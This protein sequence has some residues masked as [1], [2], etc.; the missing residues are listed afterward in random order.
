LSEPVFT[1]AKPYE[2]GC[3]PMGIKLALFSRWLNARKRYFSHNLFISKSLHKIAYFNIGFVLH[4]LH[5]LKGGIFI[6]KGCRWLMLN[7]SAVAA[8]ATANPRTSPGANK[9]I[10]PHFYFVIQYSV[11]DIHNYIR[12]TF[13]PKTAISQ[14]KSPF[15]S[16]K[17]PYS[18]TNKLMGKL[19]GLNMPPDEIVT[20][21]LFNPSEISRNFSGLTVTSII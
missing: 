4:F 21:S 5:L 2:A 14:S 12:Y 6:P 17:C 13:Y 3:F 9:F 10:F 8:T 7:C 1:P 15:F 16:E 20:S 18:R 19:I 11:F